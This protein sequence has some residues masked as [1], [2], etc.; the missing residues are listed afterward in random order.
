[1]ADTSN[2]LSLK[3]GK[4]TRRQLYDLVWST[5]MRL[6]APA[7]ACSDTWLKRMC[8]ESGV[9]TPHRG[10]WAKLAAGKKP[11]RRDLLRGFDA[12]EVVMEVREHRDP[13]ESKPPEHPPA[14]LE[15][16][17]AALLAHIDSTPVPE[18]LSK[19]AKLPTLIAA[20][21]WLREDA[22]R[23][24]RYADGTIEFGRVARAFQVRVSES[25]AERALGFL[26]SLFAALDAHGLLA[27]R[28]E[29]DEHVS[30]ASIFGTPLE[31]RIHERHRQ[32]DY[33]PKRDPKPERFYGTPRF[34]WTPTGVLDVQLRTGGRYVQAKWSD[35]KHCK[36]D[37]R[38]REILRDAVIVA[39]G[40]R[41][42]REARRVREIAEAAERQEAQ[43]RERE[44]QAETRRIDALMEQ[45][46]RWE[47]AGIVRRFADAC[48]RKASET[49]GSVV[50]PDVV[51][52][53]AWM[54]NVARSID[55]LE[56]G[57]EGV[58][59]HTARSD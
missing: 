5:P 48:R 49:P 25:G 26:A 17:V 46:W 42:S 53:L 32:R 12:D 21:R 56:T 23:S 4:L 6:L 29:R 45:A 19:I 38:L 28:T 15:P 52:W 36:V 8:R 54:D 57:I 50:P 3:P 55:P 27:S 1:M 7:F 2:S 47:R 20:R 41:R 30:F 44:R 18:D 13:S 11:K 37:D 9:P 35:G 33:D 43:R 10:Y 59:K 31:F 51:N 16:D 58:A 34:V 40:E 14:P 24:G 22:N 39:A